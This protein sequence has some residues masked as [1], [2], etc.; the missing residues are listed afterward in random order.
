MLEFLKRSLERL[1]QRSIRA[2][3]KT[4][5]RCSYCGRIIPLSPKPETAPPDAAA[6]PSR[7]GEPLIDGEAVEAMLERSRV[8]AVL[9]L[10]LVWTVAAVLLMLSGL[11]QFR[12][13]DWG[14]GQRAPYSIYAAV[15]FRYV[16]T[17]EIARLHREAREKV[18]S[19]Y[20]TD[21]EKTKRILG[22]VEDFFS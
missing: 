18:P 9:M 3:R 2:S 6:T 11:R 22:N 10:V 8:P 1:R 4:T 21:E 15:D 17:A 16:D 7:D 14:E 5:T 12:L 20:R 19:Y 13:L